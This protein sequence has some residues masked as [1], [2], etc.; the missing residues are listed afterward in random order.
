MKVVINACFGGFSLSPRAVKAYAGRKGWPCFFYIRHSDNLHALT[1][2]SDEDAFAMNKLF[3]PYAYR[4]ATV[5]ELPP[6]QANW[7]SMS[8]EERSASNA[9]WVAASISARDIAR[10][11]ADLIAVVEELGDRAS[12]R[13][14]S[15]RIVEIPDDVKWKIEEYDGNEHVAEIHRNWQ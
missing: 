4:V 8:R 10:D 7:M 1:R 15:L 11:D 12:G 14:A 6:G 13:Y 9:A 5:E 3:D 2:I